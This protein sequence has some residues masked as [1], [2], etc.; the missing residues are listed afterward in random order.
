VFRYNFTA[1]ISLVIAAAF[2]LSI[3]RRAKRGK[4]WR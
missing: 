2:A 1:A 4:A 3:A